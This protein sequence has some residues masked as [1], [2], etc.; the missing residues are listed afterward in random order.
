MG[1]GVHC[2]LL[3]SDFEIIYNYRAISAKVCRQSLSFNW[4]N[5]NPFWKR[6]EPATTFSFILIYIEAVFVTLRKVSQEHFLSFCLFLANRH[7]LMITKLFWL[8]RLMFPMLLLIHFIFIFLF[9]IY[10]M[11]L[12]R[13]PNKMNVYRISILV[14]KYIL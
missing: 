12:I 3:L 13:I 5:L 8:N 7:F 2:N 9:L 4:M 6:R 10:F 14:I 11:L 1:K